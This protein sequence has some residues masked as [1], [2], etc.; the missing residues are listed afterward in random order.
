MPDVCISAYHSGLTEQ[1]FIRLF[2]KNRHFFTPFQP[3]TPILN[4]SKEAEIL[5]VINIFFGVINN[6]LTI[7]DSFP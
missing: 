2:V 1:R 3:L 5:E 4:N 7:F 6:F